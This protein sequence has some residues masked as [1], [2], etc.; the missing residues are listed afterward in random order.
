MQKTL[1]HKRGRL[2]A[3]LVFISRKHSAAAAA[4]VL[5]IS[6]TLSAA[7]QVEKSQSDREITFW[8]SRVNRDAE[9][10][11]SRVKLANAMLQK[12]RETGD[13]NF[14][15]KA[16]LVL[17][18]VLKRS[19]SNQTARAS[20]ASTCIARHKFAEAL[21]LAVS[22]VESRPHDPYAHATLGDVYL[23]LGKLDKAETEYAKLGELNPGFAVLTRTSGLQQLKGD[24]AGAINS[25]K[26]A[27]ADGE[28]CNAP[29]S[30]LEWCHLQIGALHFAKGDLSKASDSFTSAQKLTPNNN[31]VLERMAELCAAQGKYDEAMKIYI[32]LQEKSQNPHLLQSI[33]DLHALLKNSDEASKWHQR[34]LDAYL[35][36]AQHGGAHYFRSLAMLY[37][38]SI[39]NPAE[40]LKWARKDLELRQ[41]IWSYETLAWA[42]YRNNDFSAAAENITQAL[43]HGTQDAHLFFHAGMIFSRSGNFAEGQAYIRKAYEF[44]PLFEKF[45]A[46]R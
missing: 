20:L 33:G 9:D 22:A 46:H 7:E 16:D 27:I 3:C 17:R 30:M 13:I 6:F 25:L 39:P 42:Q 5:L 12:A 35:E 44:N 19:G 2:C 34:A 31:L 32:E 10:D 23:A 26:L 21:Q 36:D 24:I 18:E 37:C 40:A 41:D 4:I 15:E 43:A 11:I 8:E 14:F 38:D 1:Y 29:P 28:E 45:H